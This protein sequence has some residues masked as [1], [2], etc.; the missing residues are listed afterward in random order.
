MRL[1]VIKLRVVPIKNKVR[2]TQIRGFGHVRR[3]QI[4]TSMKR[5]YEMRKFIA[6]E[7]EKDQRKC[8]IP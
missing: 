3:R 6:E 1:Y 5:V 7:G 4:N 8:R 2:D